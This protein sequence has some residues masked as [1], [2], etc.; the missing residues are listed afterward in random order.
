VVLSALSRLLPRSR[1][2]TFLVTPATLLRRH[3][4]LVARNWT[5]P[6]RRPGRPPV[7]AEIRQLVLRLANDIPGWGH[8]RVQGELVG[9][10]T[11]GGQHRVVRPDQRRR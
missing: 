5:Y 4:N 2:A 8:R 1:W 6:R 9:L 7:Q 3:R 11:G 10:A